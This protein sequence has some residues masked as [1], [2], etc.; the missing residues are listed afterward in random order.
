VEQ[1]LGVTL[2]EVVLN[3]KH[4]S[5]SASGS[6]HTHPI[7][8]SAVEVCVRVLMGWPQRQGPA[9]LAAQRG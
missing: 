7:L 6:L 9:L 5:E 4:A 8:V 3:S 2:Y 1:A